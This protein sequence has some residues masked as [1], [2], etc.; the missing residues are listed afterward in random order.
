MDI[1]RVTP[2]RPS[3]MHPSM[4]RWQAIL[5]ILGTHLLVT[6]CV[7]AGIWVYLHGQPPSLFMPLG[8]GAMVA[9]WTL[10]VMV[11]FATFIG[12]DLIMMLLRFTQSR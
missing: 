2:S 6:S 7:V 11:F 12:Q 9:V 5:S 10:P 3:S 1:L 4:Q 8:I